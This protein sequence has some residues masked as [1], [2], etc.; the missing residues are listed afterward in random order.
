MVLGTSKL[1]LAKSVSMQHPPPRNIFT[2][3]FN[4]QRRTNIIYSSIFF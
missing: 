4:I 1:L 2:H 3:W